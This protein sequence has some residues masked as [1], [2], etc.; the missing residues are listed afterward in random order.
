MCAGCCVS[1]G[2]SDGHGL[3]AKHVGGGCSRHAPH[4][5]VTTHIRAQEHVPMQMHRGK[6]CEGMCEH[7]VGCM[8]FSMDRCIYFSKVCTHRHVEGSTVLPGAYVS[9]LVRVPV[10]VL[11]LCVPMAIHGGGCVL[12]GEYALLHGLGLG[13]CRLRHDSAC[14]VGPEP[15]MCA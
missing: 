2:M 4:L 7:F 5:H 12:P 13:T 3:H 9:V 1:M 15:R 14:F 10:H 8:C 6:P 11:L